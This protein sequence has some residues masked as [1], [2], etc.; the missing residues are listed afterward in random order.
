MSTLRNLKPTHA[1][2]FA[3]TVSSSCFYVGFRRH[4]RRCL[5]DVEVA[6]ARATIAT[7]APSL[8]STPQQSDA[9]ADQHLQNLEK[10]GVTVVK[11]TLSPSQQKEWIDTARGAFSTDNVVINSGRAHCCVSKRSNHYSD[12]SRIGTP[13]SDLGGIHT[14]TVNQ[15]KSGWWRRFWK[16]KNASQC[17]SELR[18][19]TSTSLQDVVKS[20]F[21][22][23]GIERYGLTDLQYLNALPKSTNQI[24]HRDN[25]FRGLT[26]IVSLDDVRANG[27]TE[28][29]LGSHLP[30]FTLWPK[31]WDA[32]VGNANNE[33]D[34]VSQQTILGCIDAGDAILYD[35]RIF[36]RGRGNNVASDSSDAVRG[37]SDKDRLVLVLR[38]DALNTPPPGSGLI[39]TTTNIYAGKIM[40]AILYA[41]EKMKGG[42]Q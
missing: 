28:L 13:N 11:D 3:T 20:Y 5:S 1:I 32:A 27:P 14:S 36:H 10:Y 21:A 29:I 6:N 18:S 30:G 25:K 39:V 4:D 42:V 31:L 2:A 22:Q 12:F 33:H 15:R 9:I 19:P 24:W 23:H 37:A 26:A 35:A 8:T 7:I 40:Y 17:T 41:I 38:W 34:S 16:T